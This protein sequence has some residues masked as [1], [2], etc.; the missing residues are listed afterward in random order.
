MTAAT[1]DYKKL[2]EELIG[3]K[4]PGAAIVS[5]EGQTQACKNITI[6]KEEAKVLVDGFDKSEKIA[7]NGLMINGK[8][9]QFLSKTANYIKTKADKGGSV[10]SRTAKNI[11]VGMY[12]DKLSL[13]DCTK[14]MELVAAKLKKSG[15]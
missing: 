12:D 14:A 7:A 9:H 13:E 2:V 4:M 10:T 15:L 5:K 6:S 1:T 3:S 8:K 11:I